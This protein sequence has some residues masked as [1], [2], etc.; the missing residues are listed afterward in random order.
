[1]LPFQLS[2]TVCTICRESNNTALTEMEL[3]NV[4]IVATT[5]DML[6]RAIETR[7]LPN[8]PTIVLCVEF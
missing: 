6:N 5:R 3:A 1:M 8:L 2:V 7:I 4:H